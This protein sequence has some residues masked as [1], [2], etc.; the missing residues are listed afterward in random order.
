MS[1][2]KYEKNH[3][4]SKVYSL[5][6]D[7]NIN[8]IY[9]HLKGV[10][11][12][13]E[14]ININLNEFNN[15]NEF[16]SNELDSLLL[17]SKIHKNVRYD[18]QRKIR[19]GLSIYDLGIYINDRI[20]HYT[21]NTGYNGG[22]GFSPSLSVSDCIAHYSPTKTDNLKLKFDDNIK[23]DFGVHINGYIIDSAFTCYFDDKHNDIHKCCKE[24]L[25]EGLKE[26]GIDAPI[27][28]VSSNI[29]EVVNSYGYK[30]IKNLGGHN[31]KQYNIHGGEFVPN[32]KSI[33]NTRRFTE[34]AWAVEPFISYKTTKYYNGKMKN[35]YRCYDKNSHIYEKF[36]NLIFTDSHIEYYNIDKNEINSMIK[37]NTIKTYE[38]LYI[39]NDIGVQYEH[40][41][42]INDSKKIILS[43]HDDY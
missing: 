35:N 41:I 24:A 21:N 42:Y 40:T 9:G 6:Y 19:P 37:N 32:T 11:I 30:I 17:A 29:E 26:V 4:S 14:K 22:I 15:N 34:G 33:L 27:N 8:N 18:I 23:I 10:N 7:Y 20:R 39:K 5:Y 25:Y 2:K 38:P 16:N 13:N 3:V 31:I 28:N 43:Q 1:S 36:N 12:L